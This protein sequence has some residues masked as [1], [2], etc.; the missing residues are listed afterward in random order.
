M[1]MITRP[2]RWHVVPEDGDLFD[3][4]AFVVG[5]ENEGTGEFVTIENNGLGSDGVMGIDAR[6]C[7][8]LQAAIQLAMDEIH[9]R[10]AP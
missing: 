7:P 5:I 3:E 6:D 2:T 1:S 4:R 9:R 8:A 10:E